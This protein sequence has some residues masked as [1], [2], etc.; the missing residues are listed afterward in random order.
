MKEADLLSHKMS[1][2]SE[3]NVISLY[4]YYKMKYIYIYIYTVKL[5]CQTLIRLCKDSEMDAQ[6]T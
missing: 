2:V 1:K 3:F 6:T 4:L 5:I